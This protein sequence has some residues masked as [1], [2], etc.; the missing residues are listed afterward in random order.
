MGRCKSLLGVPR[1]WAWEDKL[2]EWPWMDRC[3]GCWTWN[4]FSDWG[5]S[6]QV[7]LGEKCFFGKLDLAPGTVLSCLLTTLV[8]EV[9]CFVLLLAFEI[10]RHHLPIWTK[11]EQHP[12]SALGLTT[13]AI[14]CPG[15]AFSLMLPLPLWSGTSGLHCFVWFYHAKQW[16]FISVLAA[17]T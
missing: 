1:S 8:D 17:S 13:P 6:I 14:C 9:L 3:T 10:L 16:I 11:A 4:L 12:S 7:L 2:L 5:K 15:A